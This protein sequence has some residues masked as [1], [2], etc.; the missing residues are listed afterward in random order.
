MGD[1]GMRGVRPSRARLE[2]V[3]NG[4]ITAMVDGTHSFISV[5][6]INIPTFFAIG[7]DIALRNGTRVAR[8]TDEGQR[9]ADEMNTLHILATQGLEEVNHLTCI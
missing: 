8:A 6:S 2:Q 4:S 5:W 1:G 3:R 9:L 7:G